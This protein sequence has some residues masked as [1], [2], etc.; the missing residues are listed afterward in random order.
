MKN[1]SLFKT[2]VLLTIL[3]MFFN[4]N[5]KEV[6][7]ELNVK[8]IELCAPEPSI[9]FYHF[10]AE[11]ELADPSIIEVQVE[12]NGKILRAT[13]L[14]RIKDEKEMDRLAIKNRDKL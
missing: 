14:H 6:T 13:D 1:K 10:I 4:I 5:A 3:F 9:P 12:V 7:K 11:I 2:A 8:H